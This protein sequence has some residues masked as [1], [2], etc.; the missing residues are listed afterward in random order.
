MNDPVIFANFHEYHD[1]CKLESALLKFF[2][3]FSTVN[4]RKSI[5]INAGIEESFIYGLNW[6]VNLS[7]FISV[8]VGKFITYKISDKRPKYHPLVKIIFIFY[9]N[10]RKDIT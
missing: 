6:D 3:G 7:E 5:L 9:N 1:V 8:L 10:H 2:S 4:G